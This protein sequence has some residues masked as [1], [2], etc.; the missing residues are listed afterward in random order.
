MSEVFNTVYTVGAR[1]NGFQ[2]RGVAENRNINS[3]TSIQRI[4]R[5]VLTI[6]DEN[7]DCPERAIA[8]SYHI[9]RERTI[10]SKSVQI[11]V[12]TPIPHLQTGNLISI[13]KSSSPG[14]P[15]LFYIVG[16]TLPVGVGNMSINA[17]S[18]R[19]LQF[20]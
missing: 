13:E 17:V 1:I 4:G 3:P 9:L 6:V 15:E 18:I 11:D 12:T 2:V 8:H 14:N 19:D 7:Y 5:R 16:F 10:L 20:S